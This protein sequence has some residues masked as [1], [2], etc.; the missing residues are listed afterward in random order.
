[1]PRKKTFKLDVISVRLVK[2][3]PIFSEHRISSPQDAVDVIGKQL[4]EMD[5]EVLCVINLKADS[6]PINCHFASIGALT[7]ALAHPRE[8]F[9]T[10]ILS[11]AAHM[12]LLHCHPSGSLQPSKE[13]T[14]M[15]DRMIKLCGLMGIR[16]LDHII[17]GGDNS[18]YF[19]FREKGILANPNH[20][21]QTDYNS[22]DFEIPMV[23]EKE[24]KR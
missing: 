4:C 22:L 18:R 9:K 17:V 24:K 11:N 16:L 12:I 13:D 3:A 1:M 14:I 2:D 21:F 6:T 7:E 10:S 19:S 8:L 23:A 15:T 5:R 20:I